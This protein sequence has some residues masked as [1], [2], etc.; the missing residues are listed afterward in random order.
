MLQ[1]GDEREPQRLA[2]FRH[3]C[4]IA[5][6]GHDAL[7]GDRLE[8]LV[9]G[10]GAEL[11]VHPARGA[12]LERPDPP[13]LAAEH[14]EADVRCDPVEPGLERRAS[15]EAVERAPRSH[16]RLLDC[17]L[18]VERR[19]EHPVAVARELPAVILELAL[20]PGWR[21]GRRHPRSL[22]MSFGATSGLRAVNANPKE[23]T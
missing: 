18:G 19:A 9:R 11:A 1:R 4:G 14:V 20:Q 21:D 13:L 5:V 12:E 22:P 17:V 23:A 2:R 15:L 8:P 10:P 7:V 16:H 3:P 6:V